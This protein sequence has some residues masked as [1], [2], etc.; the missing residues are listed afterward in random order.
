MVGERT[1]VR[2][3]TWAALLRVPDHSPTNVFLVLEH[4]DNA[5][6]LF[7][8]HRH[9]PTSRLYQDIFR[10]GCGGVPRC[11]TEVRITFFAPSR[12]GLPTHTHAHSF[13]V[14]SYL[15]LARHSLASA[16]PH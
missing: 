10:R 15:F 2:T 11:N 5:A 6:L 9:C 3:D 12:G 13:L 1:R 8:K 14:A 4:A 7:Q 16:E